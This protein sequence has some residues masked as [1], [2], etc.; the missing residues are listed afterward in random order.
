MS[1]ATQAAAADTPWLTGTPVGDADY[2]R[3]SEFLFHE[4]RLL[5]SRQYPAWLALLAPD[6]H[7]RVPLQQ[8]VKRGEERSY[9]EAPPWLDETRH[10]LGIRVRQLM[11]PQSNADRVPSFLRYFV[12]NID[13]VVAH[14]GIRVASQVLLLRVRANNP[15]PFLLSAAREDLLRPADGGLLLARREVQLDM[16]IIDAPNLAL[17]LQ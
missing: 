7:H 9:G 5:A 6:I 3:V 16:P 11:T 14:D 15:Q 17:F 8:F 10:S 13:A 4:A 1:A 12:T 2:R